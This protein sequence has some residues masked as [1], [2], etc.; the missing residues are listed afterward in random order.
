MPGSS[1]DS[2]ANRCGPLSLNNC[3][4]VNLHVF[5]QDSEGRNGYGAAAQTTTEHWLVAAKGSDSKTA[6]DSV[7][8]YVKG[9]RPLH[10]VHSNSSCGSLPGLPSQKMSPAETSPQKDADGLET[11]QEQGMWLWAVPDADSGMRVVG[12]PFVIAGNTMSAEE[13]S[14]MQAAQSQPIDVECSEV[15]TES[16]DLGVLAAKAAEILADNLFDDHRA[17]EAANVV[18]PEGGLV[19]QP[20]GSLAKKDSAVG[21]M[22]LVGHGA[23]AVEVA[24]ASQEVRQREHD[25]GV[26][27]VEVA[28]AGGGLSRPK[29]SDEDDLLDMLADKAGRS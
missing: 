2:V 18:Q 8:P 19:V 11:A 23:A 10:A 14:E 20:E 17:A 21:V 4:I 26:A 6:R 25:H 1:T 12:P 15:Y 28:A 13:K 16:P 7:G 5:V 29:L 3:H 22:V 9:N 27:A 24:A